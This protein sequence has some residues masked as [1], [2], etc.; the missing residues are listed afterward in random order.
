MSCDR[1]GS[2]TALEELWHTPVLCEVTQLPQ[3]Y[4]ELFVK[5]ESKVL[6]GLLVYTLANQQRSHI[7]KHSKR[8][9]SKASSNNG[10]G[11][12]VITL[13]VLVLAT[14]EI[15][16]FTLVCYTVSLSLY[17]EHLLSQHSCMSVKPGRSLCS[18]G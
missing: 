18:I 2:E 1:T 14:T 5:I 7:Q 3:T 16:Y 11:Y 9:S 12:V 17:T 10:L 8:F 15:I 13:L 4:S 6:S